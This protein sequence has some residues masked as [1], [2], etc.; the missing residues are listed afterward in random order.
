MLLYRS[1]LAAWISPIPLSGVVVD[2]DP[3]AVED[4]QL[5]ALQRAVCLRM[6]S[7]AD[8]AGGDSPASRNEKKEA[9]QGVENKTTASG[10]QHGLCA[11]PAACCV[12]NT[13]ELCF[14]SGKALM[15]CRVPSLLARDGDAAEEGPTSKRRRKNPLSPC[16]FSI[17]WHLGTDYKPVVDAQ[18]LKMSATVGE[19]G[20][21]D[22]VPSKRSNKPLPVVAGGTVEITIAHTGALQGSVKTAVG[23]PGAAS[24]LSRHAMRCLFEGLV[25]ECAV[26]RHESALVDHMYRSMMEGMEQVR[27]HGGGP[28][29][30][31]ENVADGAS[32]EGS[33]GN[34]DTLLRTI[35]SAS[36]GELK[37]VCGTSGYADAKKQFLQHPIFSHW[38][39]DDET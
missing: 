35:Q 38:L 1:L 32:A 29:D 39:C 2:K 4:G 15:K 11:V 10:L 36:L 23:E 21:A 17:N 30:G 3:L 27:E 13:G 19:A 7:E 25:Q 9:H 33:Q 14:P 34:V 5:H 31:A 20:S 6:H 37:R 26:K 16:G 28:C 24:R 8:F 12:L 22:R 18:T